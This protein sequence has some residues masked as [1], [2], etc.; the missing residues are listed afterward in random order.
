MVRP[1]QTKD[2]IVNHRNRK[3]KNVE[4]I[5]GS[6]RPCTMPECRGEISALLHRY[7]GDEHALVWRCDTCATQIE[8][9]TAEAIVKE[10]ITSREVLM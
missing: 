2:Q 6:K 9:G 1:R 10:P 5:K 8:Y 3:I 7:E 4:G